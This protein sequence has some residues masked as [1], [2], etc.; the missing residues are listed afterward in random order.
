MVNYKP[1]GKG[2]EKKKRIIELKNLVNK[3]SAINYKKVILD[4]IDNIIKK[5]IE[6][7]KK[8]S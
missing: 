1:K 2:R 3:L 4:T 7:E 5:D 6:N 8:I